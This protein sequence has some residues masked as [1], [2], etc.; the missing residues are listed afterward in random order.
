VLNFPSPEKL[1]ILFVIALI[2]LGPTRLPGAA[3][4][5]GKWVGQ[6]RRLASQFQE[7]VGG[8]LS[9][10]KDALTAAVGTLR[11]ELGDLRSQL[12]SPNGSDAAGA[13]PSTS[14]SPPSNESPVLVPHAAPSSGM[15]W[16]PPVPDDPSLN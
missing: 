13:S 14:A 6:L 11:S 1:F 15:P 9:D 4:T 16:L 10:P 5:V 8:A 3:R 2:V 7:E 12:T